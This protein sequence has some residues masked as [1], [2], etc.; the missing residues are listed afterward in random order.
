MKQ[1]VNWYVLGLA[2]FVLASMG[3]VW[4]AWSFGAPDPVAAEEAVAVEEE[5][6]PAAEPPPTAPEA[7][8]RVQ[9]ASPTPAPAAVAG[10]QP[11][12][13]TGVSGKVVNSRALPVADAYVRFMVAGEEQWIRTDGQGIFNWQQPTGTDLRNMTAQAAAPAYAPS[14]ALPIQP[15]VEALLRLGDGGR[16]RGRV[17][18]ASGTPIK[19]YLLAVDEARVEL[20]LPGGARVYP[21]QPF[22]S[23][24]GTFELGPL[25]PGRFDL[26]AQAPDLAP[27]FSRDVVV[28]AGQT[29][30]GIVIVVSA[31]AKVRGRVTSAT[32]G[33]P[34][35]RARVMVFDPNSAMPS[36]VA[37]TDATGSYEVTGVPQGRR[38]L[39]VQSEGFLAEMASGIEVPA[40]VEVV[41]DVQLRQ[42]APGERFSFQGIGATLGKD[43]RGIVIANLMDDS[44]GAKAGLQAGD[45]I[46]SVDRVAASGMQVGQVVELIRGEAGVPV[47]LEVERGGVRQT[48]T[49]ERGR[50]VVK[51]PHGPQG[52]GE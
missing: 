8:I 36:K 34:V 19:G 40:S 21:P 17:I 29:T 5:P 4:L 12:V 6:E 16:M 33:K 25:Q 1:R 9:A 2:A 39:R 30:D 23:D 45:V 18:D 24:D 11:E 13:F 50:V 44:P 14:P 49:I 26:R 7:P 32:D 43:E 48:V 46:V 31:G 41:R 42:G 51:S 47:T 37:V 35:E 3:V 28:A 27:G 20:P 52:P 22:S 38:S 10:E 15:G